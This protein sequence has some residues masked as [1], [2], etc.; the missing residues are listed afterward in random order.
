[1]DLRF[2]GNVAIEAFNPIRNVRRRG[3]SAPPI[4]AIRSTTLSESSARTTSI[5]EF[6]GTA[7]HNAYFM[8]LLTPAL[9]PLRLRGV[10]QFIAYL[11]KG[12]AD[13]NLIR[14]VVTECLCDGCRH[15]LFRVHCER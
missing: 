11:A 3:A 8:T 14:K 2:V 1:M 7:R 13:Q 4:T 6:A 15:T 12:I 9:S 10:A 5:M